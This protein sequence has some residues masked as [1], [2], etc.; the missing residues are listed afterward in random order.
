MNAP[1]GLPP[2]PTVA[3]VED[4]A[5]RLRGVAVRTPLL[6]S[7][8]LNEKLGGRLLVKAE[9]LQLTGSFKFRGAYNRIS[10]LSAEERSRGVVAFSSGNHAQGT[11]YAA[12]ICNTP[13]VIVMPADAPA[14]KIA[15]TRAYGAE[16]VLYDRYRED[17]EAIGNRYARDR[18][19]TLVP[20]FND[21]YIIS[22]Q[23]TVGLEILMQCAERDIIPDAVLAPASGGGLISGIS[24]AVKSRLPECSVHCG[25]PDR[26]DDIALSLQAGEIRSHDG[27]GQTFCDALMAPHPGDIT[28][29]VMAR[30]LSSSLTATD[31][32]VETAMA[33]AFHYLK[34]VVEP[35]G[36]VAL[37]AVLNGKIP[38]ANRTVVAVASGGNVDSALYSAIISRTP[39]V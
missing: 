25:E 24:L 31:A 5:S 29:G 9:P 2:L 14:I 21:P 7:P 20:P 22:G 18:G 8:L 28:F 32:E 17:R 23:G 38:C 10:R 27:K 12:K 26:F 3:D 33:T 39:P 16:V 1:A 36:A 4:A 6:E 15:N 37:A 13:A 35:G 30:N 34:L 19:M 11:A